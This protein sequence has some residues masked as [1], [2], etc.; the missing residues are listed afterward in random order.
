MCRTPKKS[1][2]RAV[3]HKAL[4]RGRPGAER[5]LAPRARV[6][7]SQLAAA[8]LSRWATGGLRDG[9]EDLRV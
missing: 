5:G 6:L 1:L 3:N 4:G 9:I 7:K 2:Q 8:E